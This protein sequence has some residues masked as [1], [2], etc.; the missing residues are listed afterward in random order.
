MLNG[1]TRVPD[2]T[3]VLRRD[4]IGARGHTHCLDVVLRRGVSPSD[5]SSWSLITRPVAPNSIATHLVE[6]RQTEAA[7]RLTFD[8][9]VDGRC[10]ASDVAAGECCSILICASSPDDLR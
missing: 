9:W 5:A 7:D 6:V 2:V 10:V 1:L 8:V 3:D 4:D